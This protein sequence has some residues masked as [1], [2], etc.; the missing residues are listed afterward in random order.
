MSDASRFFVDSNVLL[1]AVDPSD[2]TK[3]R[4]ALRWLDALWES[5]RGSLSWQVLH[6]FYVSAVK[7]MRRPP[8]KAQQAVEIYANWVPVETTLGLVRRAWHWSDQAQLSYWDAL[9]VAA[10]ERAGC[11]RLLTEDL[12]TGQRFGSVEVVNPFLHT[13]AD[14][15]LASGNAPVE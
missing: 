8:K 7:K 4:N 1:Y 12:Q 2:R 14:F 5:G 13:P 9:I 6:E 15:G 10:A 3:R 11:A